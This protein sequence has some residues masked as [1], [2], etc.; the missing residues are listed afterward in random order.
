[1]Y[2]MEGPRSAVRPRPA[3]CSANMSRMAATAAVHP[4]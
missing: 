2:E 4:S 3:D 1:M